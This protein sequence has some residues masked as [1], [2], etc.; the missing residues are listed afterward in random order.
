MGESGGGAGVELTAA[1]GTYASY[2][3]L[4]AAG[5]ALVGDTVNGGLATTTFA[6]TILGP[7][8]FTVRQVVLSTG[9]VTDLAQTDA[10]LDSGTADIRRQATASYQVVNF[11]DTGGNGRFGQDAPFPADAPGVDDQNFAVEALATL[12]V[13]PGNGG[14]WTFGVNSDDGF[15]L[16]LEDALGVIPFSAA[17]GQTNTAIV[18]GSLVFPNGRGVDDSLGAIYLGDGIYDLTLRYWE[19]TGGSALEPYYAPGVHSS[20][21]ASFELLRPVPEPATLA[22]LGLGAAFLARRRRRAA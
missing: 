2:G 21:D 20:F 13:E 1:E 6:R 5:A 8:G 16:T 14:W 22:L 10:L 17:Y 19:G 15:R 18:D 11:L 9:G 3:D 12:V 4:I 7:S